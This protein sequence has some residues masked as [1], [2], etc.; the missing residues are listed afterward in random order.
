[1]LI[2]MTGRECL[3]GS[4]EQPL[5]ATRLS[6]S[7]TSRIGKLPIRSTLTP[8]IAW[9]IGRLFPPARSGEKSASNV[10]YQ[11]TGPDANPYFRGKPRSTPWSPH[12]SC[13]T[14]YETERRIVGLEKI[15]D[16]TRQR[17]NG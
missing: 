8:S 7:P 9:A 5:T 3:P 1:M 15:R 2:S 11:T 13:P 12:D 6:C 17:G 14:A 10:T 16:L 4:V